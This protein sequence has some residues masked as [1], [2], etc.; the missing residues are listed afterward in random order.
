MTVEEINASSDEII[1]N[2][3]S[4]KEYIDAK[5]IFVYISMG[6]E[7]STIKLIQKA[8]Q[9]N[10]KVAVPK[11][12]SKAKMEFMYIDSFENLEKSKFGVLEPVENNRALP[13]EATLIIVPGLVY[14]R[15]KF[16]IGYG[17]G[18]YDRY[19]E[20]AEAR[21][22][23][24]CFDFQLVDKLERERYDLPVERLFCGKNVF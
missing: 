3:L 16:R 20:N 23:G 7:V 24:V 1:E 21:T 11:V 13:D 15:E 19:L 5:S 18:F 9:V 6:S 12:L 2:I 17:G 14:D 10:K 8:W 4:T 22:F